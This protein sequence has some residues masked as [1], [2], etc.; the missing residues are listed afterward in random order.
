MYLVN[1]KTGS[2]SMRLYFKCLRQ[3]TEDSRYDIYSL[4]NKIAD[5]IVPYEYKIDH[6]NSVIAKLMCETLNKDY[7]KYFSFIH[8]RNPWAKVVSIYFFDKPDKN[9]LGHYKSNY[10]KDSAFYYNFNEWLKDRCFDFFKI[11]GWI[12]EGVTKIYPIETFTLKQ[13]E[14]DINAF[15]KQRGTGAPILKLDGELGHENTTVHDHYSTYY[16]EESIEI[17]RKA[18]AKDIELGGYTFESAPSK[19]IKSTRVLR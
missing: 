11:E 3:Y 15:N 10:D 6:N 18:F 17:V 5:I 12:G 4:Q 7:N 2:T 8:I 1:P 9:R 14:N 13:L 16:N 19:K